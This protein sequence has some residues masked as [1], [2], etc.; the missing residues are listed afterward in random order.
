MSHGV[1]CKRDTLGTIHTPICPTTENSLVSNSK[2][3]VGSS[4]LC[5]AVHHGTLASLGPAPCYAG[6]VWLPGTVC[7]G[8]WVEKFS[9]GWRFCL[10]GS[11]PLNGLMF[12]WAG[13]G[14]VRD[15]EEQ[16]D[17]F[18]SGSAALDGDSCILGRFP[19]GPWIC[20]FVS[21]Q[22]GQDPS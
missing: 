18:S 8:P 2:R 5:T 13:D 1:V 17:A 6:E 4:C 22:K 21:Q 11:C 3:A 14:Q 9:L 12:W 10:P 20:T 16:K 15:A 7:G 19:L